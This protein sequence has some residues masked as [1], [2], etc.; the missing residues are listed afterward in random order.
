MVVHFGKGKTMKLQVLVTTMHATD[1]SQVEKMN[2]RDVDVVIANQTNRCAYEEKDFPERNVHAVMVST[3]TTG[4]S[5][6]RNIALAYASAKVVLFADDDMEF[7][8]GFA[9]EVA[10]E[11]QKCPDADAIKFYCESTNKDRPLS[12]KCPEQL[13]KTKM[14]GIMSAGVP[15]L[16]VK[17]DF[18]DKYNINF[19]NGIGPGR[20][21]AFGEDSVFYYEMFKQKPT[22]YRSTRFIAYIKQED[23]SWF[24]GYDEHYFFTVG[25]NYGHIYGKAARLVALRRAYKATHGEES[26]YTFKKTYQLIL[27]GIREY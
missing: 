25:Y 18:L 15:A 5:L 9:Q 20:E 24:T 3:N 14:R 23:S 26:K 19:P 7:V 22:V 17:K 11:F 2:L 12:Y 6:N 21:Y 16:A 10:D 1:F 8:D 4:A 13:K 27:K